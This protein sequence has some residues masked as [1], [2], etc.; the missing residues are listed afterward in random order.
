[1]GWLCHQ[2]TSVR[3][4]R[5]KWCSCSGRNIDKAKETRKLGPEQRFVHP[6]RLHPA[7]KARGLR[8]SMYCILLTSTREELNGSM[9]SPEVKGD[10]SVCV[11]AIRFEGHCRLRVNVGGKAWHSPRRQASS[12]TSARCF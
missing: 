10:M 4:S 8:N 12:E 9:W 2:L 11:F 6:D 7:L 1:M 5:T 3:H